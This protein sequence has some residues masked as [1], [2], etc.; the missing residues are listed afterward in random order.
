LVYFEE[1]G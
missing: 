1:E